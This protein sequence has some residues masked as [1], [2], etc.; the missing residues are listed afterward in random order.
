MPRHLLLD[1]APS[2]LARGN[3]VASQRLDEM[4]EGDSG[5]FVRSE[6]VA[7][8]VVMESD[9]TV[10]KDNIPEGLKIS[11]SKGESDKNAS[12]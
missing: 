5:P 10:R 3:D 6:H 12:G 7:M 4:Q 2:Q 11:I 1:S 9:L 8:D